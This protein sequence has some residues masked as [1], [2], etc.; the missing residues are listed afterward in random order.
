MVHNYAALEKERSEVQ[1]KLDARKSQQER[2]KAGQFATPAFL[3]SQM[4]E[5][6]SEIWET[7]TDRIRFLDPA[8][9]TGSLYSALRATLEPDLIESA[10]GIEIDASFTSAAARLWAD[11]GLRILK[12]DFT[13]LPPP[14]KEQRHNLI[15]TNP[16][17]V[18]HHHL[19]Q[20]EKLRLRQLSLAALGKKINGLAGLYCY[21]MLLSHEWL[22]DGGVGVW[23][24]PSE[25][26]NVNYGRALRHYLTTNVTLLRVHRFDP[27]EL[28]FDDA[29]VSSAIVVF[30]KTRPD[31]KHS[32]VLSY[33][34]TLVRP[35]RA[36]QISLPDLADSQKWGAMQT[37]GRRG[38]HTPRSYAPTLGK[39]FTIKRG[40][41]TGA[42]NFFVL[43]KEEADRRGFADAFLKPILPSPRYLKQTVVD[44]DVHGY[45]VIDTPLALIDTDL[46]EEE[47]RHI[48]PP[49]WDYLK[50]GELLGLRSRYILAKRKPWYKQENRLPA[51]F[52]CSYMGRPGA[53]R[54]TFRFFWNRTEAV[55]ANVY[56][57]LY[58]TG[59]LAE[60]LR[61]EPD[62]S[63]VVFDFLQ[64]VRD[65]ELVREGRVYGGGLHK[66][67]PKELAH[68]VA[69]DLV[70]S[71]RL[72][73]EPAVHQ[74]SLSLE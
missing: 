62:R 53:G 2:N 27:N 50:K 43:P 4:A 9:G 63:A 59:A 73:V 57:L 36:K 49:L 35:S 24:V 45:P 51:P 39:L 37:A 17:Y 6:V 11:T 67:E 30:E 32:P 28:Q 74:A 8:L 64:H 33:G 29:L 23:L 20:Q 72:Q 68:V 22:S 41:A 54:R 48:C 25:F 55:A 42:N 66:L 7:R 19:N 40:I 69:Q 71:L 12:A 31:P 52:L 61:K 5:Y 47:I 21:F 18:R 38:H 46:P 56:L 3:A 10:T 14:P 1:G 70:D 65:A 60:L 16:P 44:S 13:R 15:L 26:M 58:P 34:G